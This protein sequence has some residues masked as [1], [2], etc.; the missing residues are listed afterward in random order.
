MTS[1]GSS[2]CL[3]ETQLTRLLEGEAQLHQRDRWLTHV[4]LCPGCGLVLA[5]S[6]KHLARMN[7]MAGSERG[8][9]WMRWTSATLAILA[10]MVLVWL[11]QG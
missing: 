11:S 2:G 10:V 1:A 9:A 8:K 7:A 5:E 6:S 3:T 4:D